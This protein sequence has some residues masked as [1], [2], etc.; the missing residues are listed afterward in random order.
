MIMLDVLS[1]SMQIMS[2]LM[3]RKPQEMTALM[4]KN[5]EQL[6]KGFV[7]HTESYSISE[8]LKRLLQPYHSG[9]TIIT[10]IPFMTSSF[11]A[12]NFN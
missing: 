6:L 1:R 12:W 9:K 7:S 4:N 8:L 10:Y 2:M 3:V 5:S 11:T